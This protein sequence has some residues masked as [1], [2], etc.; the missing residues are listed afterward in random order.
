MVYG[1]S[2]TIQPVVLPDGT[3]I[4]VE[5]LL[6]A[7]DVSDR[8][9]GLRFDDVRHTF[10]EVGRWVSGTVREAMPDRPDTVEVAFGMKLAVEA[11]KLVS[12]LAKA[13]A[14]ASFSVKMTWTLSPSAN[15]SAATEEEATG[16]LGAQP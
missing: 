4:P 8:A 15:P 6:R 16:I 12:I 14:E 13:N 2:I 3:V 11:G 7:G 5:V 10:V 1:E 9:G